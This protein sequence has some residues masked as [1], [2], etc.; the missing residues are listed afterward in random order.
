MSSSSLMRWAGLAA[1]IGGVLLVTVELLEFALIGGQPESAVAGSGAL[2]TVRMFFVA[3]LLLMLLGLVGLYARQAQYTGGL[4]LIAFLLAFIGTFMVG[5]AQW[6]AA[7]IGP[8]LASAAPELLDSEPAG[9]LSAAFL[10]SFVLLA[11]GW[12]LF[13]W[14][15]RQAGVLPGGA[16][17]LLMVGAVLL[18]VL[19]LLEL[20]GATVVFGAALAWMGYALWSRPFE[21][22]PV[23]KVAM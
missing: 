10:L 17:A 22:A 1:L 4:G 11:L 16:A 6:T 19:L 13:G 14:V 15:S 21:H 8:W 7:F 2:V 9:L 3:A 5:G 23:P 12:L 18:L 20:P